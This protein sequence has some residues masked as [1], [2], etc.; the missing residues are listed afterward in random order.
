M[1]YPA[2]TPNVLSYF[3]LVARWA[4]ATL[5]GS[6]LKKAQPKRDEEDVYPVSYRC[7]NTVA[8]IRGAPG[9]NGFDC[10]VHGY[11]RVQLSELFKCGHALAVLRQKFGPGVR[12]QV[13]AFA[14]RKE[15]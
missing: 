8:R 5:K 11:S 14:W 9:R 6:L 10:V 15:R 7:N 4:P 3:G 2:R 12:V 1:R 13:F